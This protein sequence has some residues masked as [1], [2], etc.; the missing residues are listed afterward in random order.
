M[1]FYGHKELMQIAFSLFW[2]ISGM[3]LII[4]LLIPNFIEKISNS[5]GF[6]APSNMIFCVTIF[7]AFWL[8]LNLM[9]EL[10]KQYRRNVNLVQDVSILKR[11]IEKIEGKELQ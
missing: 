8:I 5:L 11:R 7:I 6:E 3:T 10:S 1:R 4:A 9:I 2:L